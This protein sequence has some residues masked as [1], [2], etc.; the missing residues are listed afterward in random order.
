MITAMRQTIGCHAILRDPGFAS[1]FNI[2]EV[3]HVSFPVLFPNPLENL[4]CRAEPLQWSLW[5][6]NRCLSYGLGKGVHTGSQ[7][8]DGH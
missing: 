1:S 7:R 5:Q 8:R 2:V 3:A 6:G 4:K